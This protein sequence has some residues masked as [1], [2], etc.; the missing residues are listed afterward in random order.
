M[1]YDPIGASLGYGLVHGKPLADVF[2]EL[3]VEGRGLVFEL[4]EEGLGG[5]VVDIEVVGC[6]GKGC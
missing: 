6:L 1:Y 3:G 5:R 4:S 2:D